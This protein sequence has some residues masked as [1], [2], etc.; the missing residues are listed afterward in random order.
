M[1]FNLSFNKFIFNILFHFFLEVMHLYY[2]LDEFLAY[3]NHWFFRS[4]V[5]FFF[6]EK[7]TVVQCD[8]HVIDRLSIDCV[9]LA[10]VDNYIM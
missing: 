5:F 4:I 9:F 6:Q 3:L 2:S 1:I 10:L 7:L 8:Q